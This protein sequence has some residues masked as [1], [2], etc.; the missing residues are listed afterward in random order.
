MKAMADIDS[1]TYAEVIQCLSK[2][3]TDARLICLFYEDQGWYPCIPVLETTRVR[4]VPHPS[5]SS[6]ICARV[7]EVGAIRQ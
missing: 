7:I 6:V 3:E 4:A 2:V 1:G 5:C